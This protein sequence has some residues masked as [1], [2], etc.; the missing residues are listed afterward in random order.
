MQTKRN[1][2][3]AIGS[4]S[5]LTIIKPQAWLCV[6]TNNIH[7]TVQ[8]MLVYADVLVHYKYTMLHVLS[9]M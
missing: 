4:Q 5:N 9:F 1:N 6:E 2:M 3:N 8:H 7:R